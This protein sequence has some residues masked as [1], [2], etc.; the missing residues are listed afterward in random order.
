MPVVAGVD[1]STQS[2]TVELRD[3]DS[4]SLLGSG[5]APHPPTTPPRSEQAASAWW[6]AFRLALS[7]ATE[8]AGV[9][10]SDIRS[11]SVA[12]QCH[13]LVMVDAHGAPLRDVKLW[14]DT[15][16]APQASRL[17]EALGVAGWVEAVGSAPIAAF[18]ITKLAWIAEHE[19]ELLDRV[20]HVMVPHDY[21]TFRL[22]GRAVTDRSDATG[23]GY[24]SA[25][26]RRWRVDL[27]ERFVSPSVEWEAVLPTV[28]GPEEAAGL[29]LPTIASELGLHPDLVV[30]PGAGDQHAGAAGLGMRDNEVAYSLGTSGVVLTPTPDPVFDLGGDVN[31]VANITGGYLPLVCTL[32]SAKVTD[33]MTRWLGVS[34]SG[35]SDLALAASDRPDRPVFAAYLDGERSP[36]RPLATG[37]I[38][39]LTNE[40]TRE[41]LARMAF[42]GVLLGLVRGH[43]RIRGSGAA[44]DGPVL[45]MGGGARSPAYRQLLADLLQ[46]EVEVRDAP[47]AT[48]RGAAIQA[49]AVLAGT[50]VASVRDHW[51]PPVIE[52]DIPRPGSADAV[53]ERYATLAAWTGADRA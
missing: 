14:N 37:T 39:G 18:T 27:L 42:E 5:R 22:T 29:I 31:S 46:R 44:A 16:S 20:A 43:E 34:H 36:N 30:G 38:A 45:V 28:L 48:A 15:T 53:A 1:S 26:E 17:L 12:A 52:R 8:A 47:E 11:M 24:Y 41:D 35:L 32:N 49:S 25:P 4:G 10:A 23:T 13:G 21:L 9:V 51:V 7:S 3:A 40:T 2:C 33:T 19:P 6:D 50:T